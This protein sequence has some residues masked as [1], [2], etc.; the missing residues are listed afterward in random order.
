M[1]NHELSQIPFQQQDAPLEQCEVYTGTRQEK[2]H[3]HG[4]PAHGLPQGQC[5]RLALSLA[6]PLARILKLKWK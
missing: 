1:H 3:P 6:L 4:P 5:Q 2:N